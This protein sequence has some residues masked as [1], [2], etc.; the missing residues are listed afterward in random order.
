MVTYPAKIQELPDGSLTLLTGTPG[1]GKSTFCHHVVINRIVADRPVIFVTSEQS[2]TQVVELLSQRGVG[3]TGRLNFVDAFTET[4]G[5]TIPPR[6]DTV[7]ANCTD[8][9]SLSI[10]IT[11]L[12][13][14]TGHKGAL[15]VFDSLTSPYL[16]NGV[17]VVRFLKLF[18]SKFAAE[19]NSVL[20]L[21][22][23]GCGKT[24]D[25][26]A[27]MSIA[28]AVI[29]IERGEDRQLLNV[30]KHPNVRPT[31]IEVQIEP[32]RVE[33]KSR[34]YF[35]PTI[36]RQFVKSVFGQ[37]ETTVRAVRGT[38]TG[39]PLFSSLSPDDLSN[40]SR[41]F[42][43]RHYRKGDTIF[44]K[45]DPGSTF[46]IINTGSVK[47]SIPSEEGSD[48]LLAY[49]RS[50]DFFGELAL[51]SEGP[52]SA[53]ATAVEP[54]E[55]LTLERRDFLSFLRCYPDVAISMLG[56]L[57]QRLR[58]ANSQL[59]RVVL[60]KPRARVAETLLGLMNTHGEET[61]EG[62]EISI[63]LTLAGLAEMIGANT[64]TVRRLLRDLQTSGIVSTRK[65]RYVIHQPEEL[66]K[67][68]SRS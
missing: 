22:D 33:L 23:E 61:P 36:M 25:L 8:L 10:A 55:T 45:D 3:E 59:E 11:K 53:T 46:H 48:M 9:N 18:L 43:R 5:L 26:I 60:L 31:R 47:L 51:L 65:Q 57:A 62:W 17:E 2:P 34:S 67:R 54:T 38:L 21:I 42:V 20:A 44:H 32:E 1:C 7:P 35:D 56:V 27:M 37:D 29:K 52:R 66:R 39:I 19:G 16:F 41:Q 50:G 28:D 30:V 64:A 14:R 40:L 4:V 6:P 15:L 63:P 13:E 58:N 68:A 49:L 24:E 12:Q